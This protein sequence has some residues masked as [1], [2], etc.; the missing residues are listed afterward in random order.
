MMDAHGKPNPWIVHTNVPRETTFPPMPAILTDL[1]SDG[2]AQL[3][4]TDCEYADRPRLGE[5][6]SV[7][8]IYEARDALWKLTPPTGTEVLARVAEI[9]LHSSAFRS[10]IDKLNSVDTAHWSDLGNDH[11][12]ASGQITSV[13][14]A[15]AGCRGVVRLGP[16]V[17]GKMRL[18]N[19]DDPCIERGADRIRLSNGMT[20]YGWPTVVLDRREGREIVAAESKKVPSVLQEIAAQHIAVSL[21][22]EA[23]LGR[24]SPVLLTAESR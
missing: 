12:Q 7:T 6:H 22:G 18:P 10:G 5:D 16:V 1:N 4:V 3:V 8:G 15:E 17:D 13:L 24:C 9:V 14:P 2:R 23:I 21:A 11:Q 20:C 19:P